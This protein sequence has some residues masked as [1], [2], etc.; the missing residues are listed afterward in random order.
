MVTCDWMGL[1]IGF[2]WSFNGHMATFS[3]LVWKW[4]LTGIWRVIEWWLN[5]I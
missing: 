2:T 5:E 1:Y 3:T 4:W